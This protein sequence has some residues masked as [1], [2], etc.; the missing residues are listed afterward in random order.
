[1]FNGVGFTQC[2]AN[3][4]WE[5]TTECDLYLYVQTSLQF[6]HVFPWFPIKGPQGD[7]MA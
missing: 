2:D 5:K 3:M 6:I 4:A 1:M 7:N